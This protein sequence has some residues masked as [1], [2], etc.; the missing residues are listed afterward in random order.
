MSEILNPTLRV[1]DVLTPNGET[2][3]YLTC[4]VHHYTDKQLVT[5]VP[6]YFEIERKLGPGH[7]FINSQC[8][9]E[10]ESIEQCESAKE[11]FINV[12][13]SQGVLVLNA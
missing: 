7:Q 5:E 2:A 11:A 10:T 3:K 12:Y 8:L 9:L 4:R 13:K 6:R 1:I